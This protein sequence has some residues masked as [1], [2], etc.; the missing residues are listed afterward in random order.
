MAQLFS[1]LQGLTWLPNFSGNDPAGVHSPN[2]WTLPLCVS[3][4]IFIPSSDLKYWGPSWCCSVLPVWQERKC[5]FGS[6]LRIPWQTPGHANPRELTFP[7]QSPYCL[8]FNVLY[9]VGLQPSYMLRYHW[10][11]TLFF[12]SARCYTCAQGKVVPTPAYLTAIFLC[13]FFYFILLFR[14]NCLHFPTTSFPCP[15]IPLPSESCQPFLLS[16]SV[17][18]LLVYFVH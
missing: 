11:F 12:T 2:G 8:F 17:F 16:M 6:P 4:F 15:T 9:N 1:L 13:L 3:H 14:H 5:W 7:K 10:L 18:I